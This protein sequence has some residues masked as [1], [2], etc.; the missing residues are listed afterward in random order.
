MR[1]YREYT[2]EDVRQAVINNKS[3]A[4]VLK[5]LNLKS[6][7]G[8]YVH[9]K[10]T[11]QR[12]NLDISHFTGQ[13]WNKGERLKDWS[14][15]TNVARI[16]FHLIAERGHKCEKCNESKWMRH[17][18]PLEVHHIDGDRTNNEKTNLNL[19]CPNCHAFTEHYR[20]RK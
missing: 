16:K 9:L 18:I 12:L 15:Y 6:A 1:K 11:I 7:G 2:D 13:G 3:L 14:K 17:K 5:E 4:G 10:Y 19:L 20:N 8:N